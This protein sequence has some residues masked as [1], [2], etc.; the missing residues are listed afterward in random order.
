M[1]KLW[2][3]IGLLVSALVPTIAYA[4]APLGTVN[5][6]PVGGLSCP[7]NFVTYLFG[8]IGLSSGAPGV[9]RAFIGILVSMLVY[10]GFRLIMDAENDSTTNE[11]KAAYGHAITGA[12]VVGA[13]GILAETFASTSDTSAVFILPDDAIF[14]LRN[15]ILSFKG[16][17][18]AALVFN[19]SFQ[20][21]RLVMHQDESQAEKA[22]KQFLFGIMGAVVVILADAVVSAFTSRQVLLL[23]NELVGIIQFLLTVLG[24]LAVLSIFIAGIFLVLSLDESLKERA[25]KSIL[26]SIVV[27]AVVMLSLSI[28]IIFVDA[29]L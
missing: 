14:T 10:Y 9:I 5:P 22:K 7:P 2:T 24:A 28:L 12:I 21:I 4:S 1:R 11:V 26:A 27:L 15:V 17:L 19:L 20:G 16:I 25:K 29:P 23:S 6:C 3:L 18:Y 13:A 8:I